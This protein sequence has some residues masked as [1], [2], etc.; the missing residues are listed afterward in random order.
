ML[1][2]FFEREWAR[3]MCADRRDAAAEMIGYV[4]AVKSGRDHMVLPPPVSDLVNEAGKQFEDMCR[5]AARAGVRSAMP[6]LFVRASEQIECL[7][8]R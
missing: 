7:A 3:S 8:V 5:D 1:T 4:A 6:S 2:A